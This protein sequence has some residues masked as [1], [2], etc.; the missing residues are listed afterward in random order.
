MQAH[1]SSS[2]RLSV[3]RRSSAQ[4]APPQV[5]AKSTG[6]NEGAGD[7]VVGVAVALALRPR[8]RHTST[9]LLV[10]LDDHSVHRFSTSRQP[11]FREMMY[12]LRAA[13]EATASVDDVD[14][15]SFRVNSDVYKMPD[16][17]EEMN[18]Y[19]RSRMER[20][21]D[22]PAYCDQNLVQSLSVPTSCRFSERGESSHNFAAQPM[23]TSF[24]SDVNAST[25]S[26]YTDNRSFGTEGIDS[27]SYVE[28]SADQVNSSKDIS[29]YTVTLKEIGACSEEFVRAFQH[30]G[31][32]CTSSPH[33]SGPLR[34]ST[35]PTMSAA[36]HTSTMD[37]SYACDEQMSDWPVEDIYFELNNHR[38]LPTSSAIRKVTTQKRRDPC[39]QIKKE[40][41]D[42][43][44]LGATVQEPTNCQRATWQRVDVA[45]ATAQTMPA[46]KPT[47]IRS[48]KPFKFV[49][50]P[51][52]LVAETM[53]STAGY[54]ATKGASKYKQVNDVNGNLCGLAKRIVARTRYFFQLFSKEFER[55]NKTPTGPFHDP[56]QLTSHATGIS[57]DIIRQCVNPTLK[58]TC[59]SE[60]SLQ[61]KDKRNNRLSTSEGINRV[62]IRPLSQKEEPSVVI[63][64]TYPN[65]K[66]ATRKSVKANVGIA[67]CIPQEDQNLNVQQKKQNAAE[68]AGGSGMAVIEKETDEEIDDTVHRRT[69]ARIHDQEKLF[70]GETRRRCAKIVK[71]K[72]SSSAQAVPEDGD[73][74]A[75]D[76][77]KLREDADCPSQRRMPLRS[78]RPPR[79]FSPIQKRRGG[80]L[81]LGK[82]P[83]SSVSHRLKIVP[84]NP[85][86]DAPCI[87]LVKIELERLGSPHEQRP[88]RQP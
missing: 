7:T 43:Y 39:E 30:S 24:C 42:M 55:Y 26:F 60:C 9:S 2:G 52:A 27:M 63:K 3:K 8:G 70:Y 11:L 15:D 67:A 83:L 41:Y 65:E 71:I 57:L 53:E 64:A 45:T 23:T 10:R 35:S 18:T 36:P 12:G 16:S 6:T 84:K 28:M 62:R 77:G 88:F 47:P 14:V 44:V 87:D 75:A 56:D 5:V 20:S 78:R 80:L 69:S 68:G 22:N 66:E 21:T 79:A 31:G 19:E 50:A 17:C 61:T 82:S 46:S 72:P 48:V 4:G 49:A 25:D 32:I 29:L 13:L 86:K 59:A 76:T 74:V 81:V 85:T 38:S 40:M 34:C 54:T 1:D 58:A 73:A 37:Q 33:S 51:K